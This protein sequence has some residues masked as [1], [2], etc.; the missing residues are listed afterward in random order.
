MTITYAAAGRLLEAMAETRIAFDGDAWTDLFAED[1]VS[2]ADPSEP[3]V[4]GHSALRAELLAAAE[5]QEQ[6]EFTWERHWV[7]PP[8]IMAP[9]RMSYVDRQSRVRV[10][11]AGFATLEI[12]QDGRI[13]RSRWWYF[14]RETPATG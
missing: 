7:V 12:G 13:A 1:A 3:S 5:V 14:R 4:V 10:S 8:T 9:W 6:V 11:F 2:Q